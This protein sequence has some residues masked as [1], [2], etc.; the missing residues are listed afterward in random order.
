MP[1]RRRRPPRGANMI[2]IACKPGARITGA[3]RASA[4]TPP[5]TCAFR[6]LCVLRENENLPEFYM[7]IAC[8]SRCRAQ[9]EHMLD[10][11][12]HVV[13]SSPELYAP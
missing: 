1:P 9:L 8:A 11:H 5:H 3:V 13:V 6:T 2:Y 4:Q 12:R 10:Y 7:F